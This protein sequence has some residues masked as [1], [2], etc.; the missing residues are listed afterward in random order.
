M[1]TQQ[2][3]L[4]YLSTRIISIFLLLLV[5]GTS[6][7]QVAADTTAAPDTVAA[8]H[9]EIGSRQLVFSADIVN[10]IRN[11]LTTSQTGYEFGMDYYTHGEL[12]LV[13]EGGWG[14]SKVAYNDLNYTT[15]NQF[16]RFGFN[17][18]LLPRENATDWGGLFMG[19]RLGGANITRTAASYSV[20]DSVWG[21]SSGA[22]SGKSFN[23]FWMEITA[24]VRVELV[25]GLLAGWNLRGKFL[26]N[27]KSFNDLSPLYIA[28][29]GRGDKNAV[30]DFNFYLS[31]AI[32]WKRNEK[33]T[34]PKK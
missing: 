10:P 1:S 21:N 13:A 27:G 34:E 23:A 18:I 31:Y 29:Y 22:L 3:N 33:A 2:D 8:P 24:G 20:I 12:Y 17:K 9:K 14:D 15:K 5:W 32:R 26:L 16:L 25:K 11:M 19:L 4:K 6:R 30:F 7:A 28:G